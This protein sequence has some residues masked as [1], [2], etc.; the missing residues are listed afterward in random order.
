MHVARYVCIKSTKPGDLSVIWIRHTSPNRDMHLMTA[1]KQVMKKLIT[2]LRE[3]TP[4]SLVGKYRSA[5]KF[6][7]TMH[8]DLLSLSSGVYGNLPQSPLR[9]LLILHFTSGKSAVI[10]FLQL[11]SF[12]YVTGCTLISF[13]KSNYYNCIQIS[14]IAQ[15]LQQP[16]RELEDPEKSFLNPHMGKRFLSLPKTNQL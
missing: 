7:L 16:G 1:G 13:T 6:F 10:D 4:C 15:P 5:S 8:H 2:V 11:L 3:A 9:R 12:L 14:A